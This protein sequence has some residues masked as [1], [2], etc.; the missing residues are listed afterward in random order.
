MPYSFGFGGS[1]LFN[2]NNSSETSIYNDFDSWYSVDD[3]M[4]ASTFSAPGN[5]IT[6]DTKTNG[7]DFNQR[8][9]NDWGGTVTVHCQTSGNKNSAGHIELNPV[10]GD[11][12]LQQ[13]VFN[14]NA[15]P[16]QVWGG[17]SKML[18]VSADLV[19]G[20]A[21][22]GAVT[23]TIEQYSKVKFTAAQTW[24]DST[25]GVSVNQGELWM[26]AG[27]ELAS[28]SVPITIGLSDGNTAKLWLSL[29]TGGQSLTNSITVNNQASPAEK[30]LGGLNTSG[31]STFQG[32]VTLNWQVN[33][34]AGTGGTVV[35]AGPISGAS[36]NVV[37]NGYQLPLAGT[38]ILSA[39]N[40]YSGNTYIAGGT[41]QINATGS[42]SNSPNLYLG[43]V[44]GTNSATL[45]LG[46][47]TG[48]QTLTNAVTVRS[49]STG[50]KTISSLAT[51]GTSTLVG[52]VALQDN[53]TV[54]SASG[55]ILAFS[56]VVS[57]T[58]F[59]LT[60]TGP[61]TTLL[62]GNNTYTGGTTI[63]AGIVRVNGQ[64]GSN[65]GTGTGSVSVNAG[66]TLSGNG[67][68][69]GAVTVANSSTAVLYP[70][71][72]A[73]L[74]ISNNL[75][76]SGSSSGVKFDLSS[77]ASGANDKVVVTNNTLACGGAQITINSAGTLDANDY[78]LFDVVGASGNISGSF[79]SLPAW[80]GTTPKYASGYRVVTVGKQVLLRYSNPIP[81]TVTAATN[82]KVYDGTTNATA[83]PT[84]TAG[85]FESG[86]S[87]SLPWTEAY[88]DK[89]VGIGTK[90]LTPILGTIQDASSMDVTAR[91]A[92]TLAPFTA[93][94][95]TQTNLTVT[96]VA[97]TKTYDGTTNAAASPTITAGSIQPG[98]TALT[99][100]ETYDTKDV[101]TGKTMTPAGLVNDSNGGANY[102]YT[103]AT[104]ISGVIT[105]ASLTV[106]GL[107]AS[108]KA[109]DGNTNAT[110]LGTGSLVGVIPPDVVILNGTPVGYF[111]DP[112]VGTGK[113]VTVT[114]LSLG[115]ANAPDYSLTPPI[116]TA[117]IT[118]SLTYS[119]TSVIL[120]IADIGGGSYTLYFQGTEGAK[121][122][123]VKSADATA[124][125][126]TWTVVGVTNTAGTGGLWNE[127]VSESAPVFYRGAAVNPQP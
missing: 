81:I 61:G 60:N 75:T 104:V 24:G 45:A 8:L 18:T 11:L 2:Y 20:V 10:N 96:A 50:P 114:G 51:S 97:N 32:A 4:W 44:S 28:T 111:A 1:L 62:S 9:E 107:A 30:T 117:S 91:Y 90:T 74:T 67:R 6:W 14:D 98:D 72:S 54:N 123:V 124:G 15:S 38:I 100:T 84:K 25:H 109:Y 102:N 43:E 120:S 37:V 68:I 87:L 13:P 48:G 40:T 79:N 70:N 19:G 116:L 92:I 55:G 12:I 113:P 125:M 126:N 101:G 29:A 49:G 56:G 26:D 65:S 31:T 88:S 71:S 78:V 64:T 115:G 27:G 3:I 93:G 82:I 73:A 7:F 122:Y 112:N 127:T 99:W 86:D 59:G 5:A 58:G 77:S 85:T 52:T 118:N 23:L 57:G 89:H 53:L 80:S 106:T 66:G 17:N 34:S 119:Q 76:F 121:Y 42:V 46:S 36:Q 83:V 22:K 110:I 94:T 95:I 21:G 105:Q 103:Y 47:A 108:D 33:L 35:F 41:L 63:N 69:A 39:T 16:Y